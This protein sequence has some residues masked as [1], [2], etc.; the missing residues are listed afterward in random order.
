MTLQ[1][2]IHELATF[3]A[4]PVVFGSR[5]LPS[6]VTVKHDE[7]W[8]SYDNDTLFYDAIQDDA[9]GWIK[10][11][12]PTSVDFAKHLKRARWMVD[13]KL[14]QPRRHKRFRVYE[15]ICLPQ[16]ADLK[17][18]I[19]ERTFHLALSQADHERYAGRRVLYTQ[20]R[21]DNLDWVR[22]WVVAHQRNHG[23]DAVL[24]T[25]N[26]STAY[27]SSTLRKTLASI[28]GL[29]IADVL[30]LP[31]RYGPHPKT[32]TKVGLTKFQQRLMLNLV[33][34]RWFW[35]A[36]GVL[37]CDVDELVTSRN[38]Q[39]IFETTAQSWTKYTRFPGQWRYHQVIDGTQTHADHVY[40]N[41]RDERCVSKFCIVP[42]SLLGRTSWSVHALEYV[43]RR[44]F[45]ASRQFMHYHCRGIT[46]SWKNARDMPDSAI[47]VED[48]ATAQFMRKTFPD[49]RPD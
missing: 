41:D 5:G 35:K 16:G 29:A 14:V 48:E 45:P 33:R 2:T 22:D 19:D 36:A 10:L 39:S 40:R 4:D 34:D 1:S 6:G 44:L 3:K 31:L 37:I 43:N 26:D 42:D 7:F 47:L 25:N 12:L 28:A 17:L 21:N 9:H 11:F 49:L 23:V 46:T 32:A 30:D 24:V 20:V 38:G 8:D 27:D 15:T 18:S 13:G